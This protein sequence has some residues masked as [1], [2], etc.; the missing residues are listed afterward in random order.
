[1]FLRPFA[2]KDLFDILNLFYRTVHTV[3]RVDYTPGQLNAW[4]PY[5]SSQTSWKASLSAH[6]SFVAIH[7][8]KIVGFGDCDN[9]G[10]LDRLYCAFDFQGKGAGSLLTEKLEEQTASLGIGRIRTEAS[11]MARPFFESKGYSVI[12][13]QYKPLRGKS[14]L[15]YRMEKRLPQ[16]LALVE[17]TFGKPL[18]GQDYQERPGAYALPF[19][20]RGE[21]GVVHTPR[22]YFLIG[23]GFEGAETAGEC[24]ARECMEETGRVITIGRKICVTAS[25]THALSDGR[26]FHPIAHCFCCKLGRQTALPMESSH[27]LEWLSVQKAESSLYAVHQQY[28]L[29]RAL[30]LKK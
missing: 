20:D 29:K 3:G 26:P 30:S 13:E 27:T 22:G 7:E 24:L 23:G 10:Y 11:I 16:G 17:Q 5:C 8:N 2:Q 6:R 15:N 18:P 12:A 28:A 25:Y 21:L 9:A 1:M 14:F 19:N 4:A